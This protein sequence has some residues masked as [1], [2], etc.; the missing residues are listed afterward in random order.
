MQHARSD[1]L[2]QNVLRSTYRAAVSDALL[3][4]YYHTQPVHLCS[5]P[6]KSSESVD[7]LLLERFKKLSRFPEAFSSVQYW[8]TQ[9]L[10]PPT[11]FGGLQNKLEQLLDNNATR[12]PRTPAV[13]FKALQVR[14]NRVAGTPTCITP[15]CL[16]LLSLQWTVC[17]CMCVKRWR[18]SL[19]FLWLRFSVLLFSCANP[20]CPLKQPNGNPEKLS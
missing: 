17:V 14:L 13:I 3:V 12:S 1:T 11:D 8:G 7:R 19:S 15:A 10:S 4:N 18:S 9:T 2:Q 16:L 20:W 6:D 5:S